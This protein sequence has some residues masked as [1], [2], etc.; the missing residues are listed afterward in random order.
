MHPAFRSAIPKEIDF[1]H[2]KMRN[3]PQSGSM[4]ADSLTERPPWLTCMGNGASAASTAAALSLECLGKLEALLG[5]GR[6]KTGS[7]VRSGDL[8]LSDGDCFKIQPVRHI[9]SLVPA[10]TTFSR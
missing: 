9:Q 10:R 6:K 5:E 1:H 7:I 2:A 8:K 3:G 4:C